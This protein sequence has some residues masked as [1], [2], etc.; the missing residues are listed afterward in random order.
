MEDRPFEKLFGTYP[1]ELHASSNVISVNALNPNV[2]HVMKKSKLGEASF[3]ENDLFSSSALVEKI[4]SDNT[5]SPICDNSSDTESI[6]FVIPVEIVGKIMNECYSGDGTVHPSDH[7]LKLKEICELFKVAGLSRENAMKKLFPFSLKDQAREWYKLLF[8]PHQLEWKELESLFYFKFYPPHEVHLG[9]N[10]I[11]NFCPHD[12]ESL[13]QAWGRLKLLML[14][15][16]IHELPIDI[17]INNFYA[18]LA[19]HY[20]DYLDACLERSFT[21]KEVKAKWDLLETI[22]RNTEDWDKDQGKESGINYEYDCIKSFAEAPNFQD[23]SASYRLGPQIIVDNFRAFA[24]HINVP[25]EDWDMY[26]EHFKD[27]C[28]KNAIVVYDGNEPAQTSESAISYE[29]VNF[30][31]VHRPC[32]KNQIKE[33]YCIIHRTEKTAK[34]CMALSKLSEKICTLYPFYCELFYDMGHFNFQCI[35]YTLSPMSPNLYCDDKI[36]PNEHDELILFLGCE[37]ILRKT[38]LVDMSVFYMSSVLHNCHLYCVNNCHANTYIQNIIK[39]DTLPKYDR[40]N[41]CFQLINEKEESS[42][43]SY[44]VS[45]DKTGYVEKLP[46]PP[47]EE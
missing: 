26:H 32:E 38:S 14:K 20:K 27:T 39:D 30:C 7:L 40:T 17:V 8:D 43:V 33:D 37:E 34:W 9:R 10:Y 18:R 19:E 42:K 35:N 12:G 23:L 36:T 45:N 29:H 46:F 4:C 5:L 3:Y 15:C 13:A 44:I 16:P 22:Q 41:M 1:M 24:S 6:L 21:R 28:I 11:Y 2:S 25:K 47:K 31:G